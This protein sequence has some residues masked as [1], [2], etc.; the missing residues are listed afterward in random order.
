MDL[1]RVDLVEQGH[2]HERVEDHGEVL[3]GLELRGVLGYAVVHVEELR[4][5][6]QN[7]EYDGELIDGVADN[8]LHHGARDERLG[9]AVRLAVEQ[10]LGG[11][12]G[13]QRQRRQ[14]VHDQIHPQHLHGS[15]RTFL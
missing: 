3:R 5:G 13:R 11:R 15:Q 4:T 9:A 10:V 2:E 1:P 8:V 14:R 12:L 6:E 7:G